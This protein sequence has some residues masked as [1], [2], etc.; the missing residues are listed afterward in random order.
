MADELIVFIDGEKITAEDTN[1]NNRYL[2]KLNSES[3]QALQNYLNTELS[4][5]NNNVSSQISAVKTQTV[6]LT[7][8]QTITGTKTFSNAP[9]VPNSATVGTPVTTA[10]ISKTATQNTSA[11]VKF[12]NGLIIQWM[13]F[14]QNQD[15]QVHTWKIPFTNGNSYATMLTQS[16]WGQD[17]NISVSAQAAA[18]FTAIVEDYERGSHLYA[19]A[20]G[21]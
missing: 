21:Y 14:T 2:A 12:G 6:N 20:I 11:C 13:K 18:N 1:D 8:N 15:E 19:I 4:K 7:G 17:A 5:I 16:R 9:K 10:A 3:A